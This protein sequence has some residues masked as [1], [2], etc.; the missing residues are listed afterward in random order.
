MAIAPGKALNGTTGSNQRIIH[1]PSVETMGITGGQEIEIETAEEGGSLLKV[2]KKSSASEDQEQI[3]NDS[4]RLLDLVSSLS[5]QSAKEQQVLIN[6]YVS[7]SI[8]GG[9]RDKVG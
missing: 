7:N 8:Y 2:F 4:E 1:S 5:D 9:L 3:K 6:K